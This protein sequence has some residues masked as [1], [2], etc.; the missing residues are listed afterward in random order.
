MGILWGTEPPHHSP[1]VDSGLPRRRVNLVQQ[2]VEPGAGDV[3]VEV[4]GGSVAT[5]HSTAL[6][7]WVPLQRVIWFPSPFVGRDVSFA[8]SK[9]P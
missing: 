9:V 3:G 8:I 1:A 2:G 4:A 6:A 5:G 7:Y